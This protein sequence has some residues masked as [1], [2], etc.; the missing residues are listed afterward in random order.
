[1][2]ERASH[3]YLVIVFKIPARG[4]KTRRNEPAL[5]LVLGSQTIS[6]R[7]NAQQGLFLEKVAL[8]LVIAIL[9][10]NGPGLNQA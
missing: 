7:L 9:N 1:M 2:F 5:N 8:R 3:I 10:V 6:P 4:L